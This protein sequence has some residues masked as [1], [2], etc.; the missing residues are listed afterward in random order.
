[1]ITALPFIFALAC[2]LALGLAATFW[3]ERFRSYW[4]RRCEQHPGQLHWE[5]IARRVRRPSY[6]F[7]LRVVG[8]VSLIGATICVWILVAPKA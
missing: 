1:M 5:V 4:I 2:F 7:E 3:T 6:S 8:I